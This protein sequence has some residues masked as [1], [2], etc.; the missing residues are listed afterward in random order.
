[1]LRFF[2]LAVLILLTSAL[3]GG[4][5]DS[6]PSRSFFG[7]REQTVAAP[8]VIP[9]RADRDNRVLLPVTINDTCQ[10]VMMLDTGASYTVVSTAAALHAGMKTQEMDGFGIDG[11]GQRASKEAA[12]VIRTLDIGGATFGRIPAVVSGV[13]VLQR[14]EATAVDGVLGLPLFQDSLLTVDYPNRRLIIAPGQLPEAD[15]QTIFPIDIDDYGRL[16]MTITAG[17]GPMLVHVDTGYSGGLLI[18]QEAMPCFTQPAAV[19]DAG[20]LQTWHSS[21][22]MRLFR[23]NEPLVIGRHSFEHP[24]IAVGA[25]NKTATLGAD[26][27]KHFAVTIDTR[28]RR[29]RFERADTAPIAVPPI[30]TAGFQIDPNTHEVLSVT[31]GSKAETA[32]LLVGDRITGMNGDPP[33]KP[34]WG[35]AALTLTA[36]PPPPTEPMTLHLTIDRAGRELRLDVP[37]TVLLE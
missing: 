20:M 10:G 35:P 12:T 36:S 11:A 30:R 25:A 13:G 8:T 3:A 18:P 31:P 4:C 19:L 34:R 1:M 33:A 37:M 28:N 29:I 14:S 2:R 9:F 23:A 16:M 22:E 15:G 24:I 21:M 17:T 7:P 27:L 26:Y 5:V 6:Q 32:G